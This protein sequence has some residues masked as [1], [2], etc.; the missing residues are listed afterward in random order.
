MVMVLHKHH[1]NHIRHNNNNNSDGGDDSNNNNRKTLPIGQ[2][3]GDENTGTAETY[4]HFEPAI[5]KRIKQRQRASKREKH[6][7]NKRENHREIMSER[8]RER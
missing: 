1:W 5:S 4:P 3:F 8:T 7:N 6:T 2:T